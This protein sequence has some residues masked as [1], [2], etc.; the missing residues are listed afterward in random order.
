[1]DNDAHT[2]GTVGCQVIILTSD[3][4]IL[5]HLRDDKP[6]IAFPDTWCIP[7]GHLDDGEGPRAC[8]VR[9]LDEEM[10]IQVGENDVHHLFSR[11]RSYGF[12]HT[13][14]IRRDVDTSAIRITEGR[15]LELHSRDA[16]SRMHLGYEDNAVLDEFFTVVDSHRST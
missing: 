8:I 9:E 11:Q 14:W 12:E 10:Q 6:G 3:D 5:L 4:R 13:Y 1:M 15:A 2:H 16:V 7:G